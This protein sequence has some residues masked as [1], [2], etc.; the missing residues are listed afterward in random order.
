M[1]VGVEGMENPRFS[2]DCSEEIQ[3][4]LLNG[5]TMAFANLVNLVYY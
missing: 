3:R 5:L 2:P 4:F 1:L